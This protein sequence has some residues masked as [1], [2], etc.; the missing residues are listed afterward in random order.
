MKGPI[1]VDNQCHVFAIH[2]LLESCKVL[3]QGSDIGISGLHGGNTRY[4]AFY[5]EPELKDVGNRTMEL[6]TACG[7]LWHTVITPKNNGA[8]ARLSA[9]PTHGLYYAKRFP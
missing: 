7:G 6:P 2:G 9:D 1:N 4:L 3:P 8:L 5:D